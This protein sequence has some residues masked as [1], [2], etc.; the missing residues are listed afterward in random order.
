MAFESVDAGSLKNA[1]IE[2]KGRLNHST[3]ANLINNLN[4]QNWICD[5]KN[6]LINAL[7][8]LNGERYSTLENKLNV[9]IG[10]ADSIQRVKNLQSENSRLQSE[11]DSLASKLY[12]TQTYYE[13]SYDKEGNLI[14]EAKKKTV[15][16]WVVY[17]R[18]NNL[19]AKIDENR[20]TI[21]SLMS[22]INNSI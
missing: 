17:S 3:T 19:R 7:S 13:E 22:S 4:G 5:S 18:R 20:R 11:Y 10:I 15:T 6:N 16:D 8:K 12:V 2:C 9:Y 21:D 14:R 1:L